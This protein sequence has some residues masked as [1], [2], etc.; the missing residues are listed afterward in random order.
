M[1]GPKY[2]GSAIV[3]NI[4]YKRLRTADVKKKNKVKNKQCIIFVM[5]GNMYICSSLFALTGLL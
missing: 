4:R 5:H 1:V 3:E 2:F